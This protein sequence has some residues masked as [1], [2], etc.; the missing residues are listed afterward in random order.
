MSEPIQKIEDVTPEKWDK[1]NPINRK[2]VEEYLDQSTTLSDQTLK[3]YQSGLK[4]YYY[5]VFEN[6]ENVPFYELKSRDFLRFQNWLI[7]LGQSSSAI[8]FKRSCVSTLNN[9]ISLMYED[10]YPS[11][12]NYITRGI[13][14]PTNE[15]KHEKNPPTLEEYYNLCKTLEE[16]EEWQHLAYLKFS[17][18]T[19]ARR[20][21]VRQL[22]KEVVSYEP[23]IIEVDGIQK[24]IWASHKI[25]GKGKGKI[26][27]VRTLQFGEDAFLALK[28][29]I[30]FRGEDDC[31]HVFVTRSNEKYIQVSE[32]TFNR[33][34]ESFGKIVGRRCHPHIWREARATS[35]VVE[36]GKDINS[37][38]K[39][40]S[41]NSV[42]T[43]EIYVI[44]N[45]TDNAD[46]AFI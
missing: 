9:W 25:R 40:L 41:H 24:K 19:G 37:V 33:W 8:K 45:D 30:E 11:F 15:F 14:M 6:L 10:K 27:K 5:W 16:N 21:E 32:S 36:Q 2:M 29:W 23:R 20:N 34:N 44:R 26:G 28:K 7:K 46:D 3:Q 39:L 42:Q 31:P 18:E 17:F 35:M 13:P 4:I 1:V 38:K 43:S 12:R 22:L